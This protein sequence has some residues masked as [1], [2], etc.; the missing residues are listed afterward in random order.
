MLEDKHLRKQG[1]AQFDR[2]R[3]TYEARQI[4][5]G[6]ALLVVVELVMLLLGLPG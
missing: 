2:F 4:V 5:Q 6:P 3:I 1:D